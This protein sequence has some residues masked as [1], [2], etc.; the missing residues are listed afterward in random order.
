MK[1]FWKEMTESVDKLMILKRADKKDKPAEWHLVQVDLDETS[2]TQARRMGTYHVK[3]Y[4]RQ[5]KDSRTRLVRNCRYWPLIREL[6]PDGSFGDLVIIRPDKVE[7]TLVKKTY[8]RGWYQDTVN[9]AEAGLIGPFNFSI[10]D[11]E[12]YRISEDIWKKLEACAT[13]NQGQST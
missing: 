7:E 2:E 11:K 6:K 1:T 8:T 5:E 4:V 10:I 13:Q 12:T 3:Y 9:L